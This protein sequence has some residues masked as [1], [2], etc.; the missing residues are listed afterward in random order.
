M[1]NLETDL[2]RAQYL[3]TLLIN[4][5]TSGEA[6]NAEYQALRQYFLEQPPVKQLVPAW[7]RINRDLSQFWQ[8]IK[9]KFPTYAER[10][11]FIWHE[12]A[13]LLEFLET[14]SKIPSEQIVSEVLERF[15]SESVHA[16]WTKALARLNS[17]P[18]GAI[19]AA[20]T[21]LES[22]CKHILD[23]Q[24]IIYQDHKVDL[25]QLYHLV[26]TELNLAPNQ[27]T[28]EV[29]KQ[30]LGGCTSVVNGL[31]ALRNRLG[32]AHGQGKR[33]IRPAPRHAQLA[34]NLAGSMALFLVETWEARNEK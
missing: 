19:T 34:I 3:Q 14:G 11:E 25:P 12:F 6:S 2:E 29:F 30:I 23:E 13:P 1:E 5:A 26:S 8:F 28:E 9:Y 15:N 31:G 17:D 4:Q 24:G 7:V 16:V 18:D 21:L 33:P 10:R 27:Y 20:R 32:D 22:I